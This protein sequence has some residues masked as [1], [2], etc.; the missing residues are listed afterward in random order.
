MIARCVTELKLVEGRYGPLEIAPDS[1]WFIIPHWALASGW[2]RSETALLLLIPPGY[3]VTPP[4]NFFAD[5]EL[6]LSNGGMPG[7]ATSVEQLAKPWLQFSYHVEPGDW[8]PHAEPENGHN[9]LT[10]LQGVNKRL[11]ELS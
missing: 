4:D 8:K 7:N 11:Q 2:N 6:R 10:F 5:V 3:P 1:A 9:L